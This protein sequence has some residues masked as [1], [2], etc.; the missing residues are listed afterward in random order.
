MR[1]EGASNER[2][3][4]ASFCR[5]LLFADLILSHRNTVAPQH[6]LKNAS[7]SGFLRGHRLICHVAAEV[8]ISGRRV[9]IFGKLAPCGGHYEAAFRQRPPREQERGKHRC[10]GLKQTQS[11]GRTSKRAPSREGAGGRKGS[12]TPRPFVQMCICYHAKASACNGTAR[13]VHSLPRKVETT[14]TPRHRP[15]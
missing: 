1:T 9:P 13:K 7:A 3:I 2:W 8:R 6:M 11:V 10:T 14:H 4:T 12:S 5:P 15:T